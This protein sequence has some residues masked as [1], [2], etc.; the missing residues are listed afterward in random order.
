MLIAVGF[1]FCVGFFFCRVLVFCG[2]VWVVGLFLVICGWVFFVFDFFCVWLRFVLCVSVLFFFGLFVVYFLVVLCLV[3]LGCCWLPSSLYIE[4]RD[5]FRI[6]L[7][8]FLY[9]INR[10]FV[11]VFHAYSFK[12]SY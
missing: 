11:Y 5:N 12:Y 1:W 7:R 4:Y 10:E 3:F 6:T 2:G 8:T 9:R